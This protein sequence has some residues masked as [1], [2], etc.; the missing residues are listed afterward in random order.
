MPP[1]NKNVERSPHLDPS[2]RTDVWALVASS[3]QKHQMMLT[4]SEYRRFLRPLVLIVNAEWV[5]LSDLTFSER[6]N[7]VEKI[8]HQTADN[9][10]PKHEY[11]QKVVN[12]YPA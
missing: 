2:I 9:P 5:N 8:I 1:L 6:I 12:K 11:F 3:E 10:A 4:V 7:T